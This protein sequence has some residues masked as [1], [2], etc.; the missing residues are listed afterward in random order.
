MHVKARTVR[1]KTLH[2]YHYKNKEY[3]TEILNKIAPT[4]VIIYRV[5][6]KTF[7][8]SNASI[9]VDFAYD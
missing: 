6:T 9:F 4:K 3:E 1:I 2:P 8:C 7:T 5:V